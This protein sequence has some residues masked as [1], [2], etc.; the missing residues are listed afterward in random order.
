MIDSIDMSG[1]Q[2]AK[3]HLFAHA[4]K[5]NGFPSDLHIESGVNLVV[6]PNGSGKSTLL[7]MLAA[8]CGCVAS[9][10]PT[11]SLQTVRESF[12]LLDDDFRLQG[13]DVRHDGQVLYVSS[14]PDLKVENLRG[15]HDL[16]EVWAGF[17]R[18]ANLRSSSGEI[19]QRIMWQALELLHQAALS[20]GEIVDVEAQ[21]RAR[22]EKRKKAFS[23]KELADLRHK[24]E[25]EAWSSGKRPKAV[26]P[27]AQDLL[28]SAAVNEVWQRRAEIYRQALFAPKIEP[29]KPTI[30]LDEPD[31]ALDLPKQARLWSLLASPEVAKRY[32][33][34]VASHSPFAFMAARKNGNIHLIEMKAGYAGEVMA[35]MSNL[36]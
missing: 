15:S 9:S 26:F 32:Q 1:L 29:S 33:V 36:L 21:V 13:L 30:I 34:I 22:A 7:A 25:E 31:A 12:G 3:E 23:E 17:A 28:R 18:K 4:R 35:S 24:I 20:D 6:G 11:V 2:S 27:V 16:G 19:T 5:I 8:G 14:R 10:A